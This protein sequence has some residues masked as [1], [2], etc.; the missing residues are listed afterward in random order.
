MAWLADGEKKSKVSLFVL[1]QLT[2][3]TNV[4]DGQTDRRTH[5]QTDIV[6]GIVRAMHARRA[7]NFEETGVAEGKVYDSVS[8]S[9]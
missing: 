7:I 4:S 1:A 9:L 3:L 2:N 8:W 6:H 5:R